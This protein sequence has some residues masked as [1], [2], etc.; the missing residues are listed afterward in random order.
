MLLD[1]IRIIV[2][3]YILSDRSQYYCMPIRI[4]EVSLWFIAMRVYRQR[5]R[6]FGSRSADHR[7]IMFPDRH[8]C[9]QIA[10]GS[11]SLA[12]YFRII[13]TMVCLTVLW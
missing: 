1:H 6:N 13:R 12:T 2:T 3:D 11:L 8:A 4:M 7:C 9:G 10:S 5:R